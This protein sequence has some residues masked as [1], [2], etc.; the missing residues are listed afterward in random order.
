[1]LLPRRGGMNLPPAQ[2]VGR[3]GGSWFCWQ[4]W[5]LCGCWLT[6]GIVQQVQPAPPLAPDALQNPEEIELGEEEGS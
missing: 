1:M 3:R 2:Q 6:G 4:G 5:R